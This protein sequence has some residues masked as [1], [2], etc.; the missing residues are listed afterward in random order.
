MWYKSVYQLPSYQPK[1]LYF[2][3]LKLDG[4]GIELGFFFFFFPQF[5][6]I[7]NMMNFSLCP[8]EKRKISQ[9]HTRENNFTKDNVCVM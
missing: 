9:F 3:Y 8:Q 6:D 1:R 7:E 5:C 2:L 4:E